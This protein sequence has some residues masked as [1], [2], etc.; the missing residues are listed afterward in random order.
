MRTINSKEEEKEEKKEEEK[1][2]RFYLTVWTTVYKI[3]DQ[4]VVLR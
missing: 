2:K 3:F 1:K 4:S